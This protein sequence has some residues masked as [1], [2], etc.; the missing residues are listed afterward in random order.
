MNTDEIREKIAPILEN[1]YWQGRRNADIPIDSISVN[2][3]L[4]QILNTE[5]VPERGC[6]ICSGQTILYRKAYGIDC[7]NCNGTGIEEAITV[8]QAI[9]KAQHGKAMK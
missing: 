3:E 1:L 6:D 5:I 9:K 8:E 2:P 4:D 7:P